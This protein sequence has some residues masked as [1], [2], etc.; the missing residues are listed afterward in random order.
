MKRTLSRIFPPTIIQND[1]DSFTLQ[2]ITDESFQDLVTTAFSGSKHSINTKR[3][4]EILKSTAPKIAFGW[5]NIA[6][7]VAQEMTVSLAEFVQSIGSRLGNLTI[8]SVNELI[9]AMKKKPKTTMTLAE[10]TY[11]R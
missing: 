9:F 7:A 4:L 5:D 11:L 6:N 1:L 2:L 10:T 3:V 8:N